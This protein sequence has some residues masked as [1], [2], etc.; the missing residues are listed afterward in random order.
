[1][2]L[3]HVIACHLLALS[4]PA[5]E[6]G[7]S[8]PLDYQVVQRNSRTEG[9]LTIRGTQKGL[10][11][12]KASWKAKIGANTE[13]QPLKV[14]IDRDTFSA[15]VTAPAGGWHHFEIQ[16]L[17][18]GEVVAQSTVE[19]V[20]VG[21]VFVVA[22]Q[23]NSANHG[24]E[25]QT[26]QTRRV[27]S[28]DGQ[29]WQM[30]NDPQ[31][32][33]SGRGGSFMPALGD[34]LVKRLDVPVGFIACGIGATS[35]RE[36]LPKGSTFP[37]PPT[38]DKR[39]EKLPSGEWAS[40]GEAYDAFI[41]RVKPFCPNGF[42]AVLWH[43]GES[44]ANQKDATRTLSG[45]LYREYLEKLIRDSRS[46]T[47]FDAPWFVAQVSY[48]TP[49]DEGSDDIRA[50]QASLWRDGIAHEEPDSDA[51]KGPLRQNAG[52]GVHFSGPGLREHGMKWAEKIT[53]WIEA[54]LTK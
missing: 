15:S 43:Q 25:K 2:K 21:E 24:E 42:R 3:R 4:L 45:R 10:D 1:M 34:E 39:V 28:F 36:W 44:D 6:I 17:Q 18:D 46:D 32:G 35:V 38:I 54:E 41:A 53:P 23:S 9:T 5:A 31:P 14:E 11:V 49:E 8:A 33:A 37:N 50:A 40:K 51:L 47:S 12:A 13:W 52:Q 22:G 48:H 7:L 26:T 20:G 19:H 16:A 30:A 27:S 29:S